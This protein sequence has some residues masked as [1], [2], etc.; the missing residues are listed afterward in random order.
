M[1]IKKCEQKQNSYDIHASAVTHV[2]PE[3]TVN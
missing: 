3:L 1:D 2:P